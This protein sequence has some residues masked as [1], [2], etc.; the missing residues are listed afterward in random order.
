MHL[1]TLNCHNSL[2]R[3]GSFNQDKPPWA[4]CSWPQEQQAL[5]IPS[6]FAIKSMDSLRACPLLLLDFSSTYLVSAFLAYLPHE[7]PSLVL[8]PEDLPNFNSLKALAFF[9]CYLS[10]ASVLAHALSGISSPLPPCPTPNWIKQFG[11]HCPTKLVP[12]PARGEKIIA[13]RAN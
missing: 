1:D 7:S 4:L 3:S 11:Q 6:T 2:P 13:L 9:R 12:L 8:R 5:G 10:S